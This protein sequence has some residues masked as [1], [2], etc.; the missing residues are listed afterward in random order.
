MS[1][2]TYKTYRSD[3]SNKT[4]KSL[5]PEFKKMKKRKIQFIALLLAGFCIGIISFFTVTEV[6][7]QV[8]TAVTNGFGYAAGMGFGTRDLCTIIFTIVNVIV[9]FLAIVAV[10][11]IAYGGLVWMT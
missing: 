6:F 7:A 9:G 8:R 3:K 4:H 10:L 5:K 11:I 1:Y 2:R